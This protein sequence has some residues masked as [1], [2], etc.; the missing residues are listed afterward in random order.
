[1]LGGVVGRGDVA[2][3]SECGEAGVACRARVRS[4]SPQDVVRT[5][6][7]QSDGVSAARNYLVEDRFDKDGA[8]NEE[9][10]D[11]PK[12]R[13]ASGDDFSSTSETFT[14]TPRTLFEKL[15]HEKVTKLDNLYA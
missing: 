8:V 11:W 12:K 6:G 10:D 15:Y 3:G 1:M 4:G 5:V 7:S 14:E 2:V 9:S 13:H